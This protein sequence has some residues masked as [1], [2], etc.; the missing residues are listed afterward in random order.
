MVTFLEK[1]QIKTLAP[2]VFASEPHA[3]MSDRYSFVSSDGLIDQFSSLGWNVTDAIQPKSYKR[4]GANKKH[5]ITFQ[6]RDLDLKVQDPR[7]PDSEVLPQILVTNSSDG[8]SSLQFAAGLFALVCSNGL[9]V[10]T[11]DLGSFRKRHMNLGMET[12]QNAIQHIAA[13]VPRLA[14]SIEEMSQKNL[15]HSERLLLADQAKAA[16]WGNDSL[17]DS[18]MLLN[19]RRQEDAGRDLWT[20][21]NVIQENT[22]QGGFKSDGQK[23]TARTLTNLD[24]LQRVNL[25]L[26]NQA[27]KTLLETA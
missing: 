10:Q 13:M 3:H 1:D 21:F 7:R 4:S 2:S 9:V 26:W 6:P 16:R 25:A 5:L 23:R 20:T 14:G 12:V 17:V 11:L 19:P 27:E 22:I 15:S 24:A 8:S 18:S